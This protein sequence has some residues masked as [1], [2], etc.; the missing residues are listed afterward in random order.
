MGRETETAQ[1]FFRQGCRRMHE[2]RLIRMAR[3]NDGETVGWTEHGGQRDR[4]TIR[5]GKGNM[6]KMAGSDEQ[7]TPAVLR[8]TVELGID[9]VLSI[10]VTLCLKGL[11][12]AGEIAALLGLQSRHVLQDDET[13]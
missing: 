2:V 3:R 6:R 11:Q 13:W 7:I 4:G 9:D 1:I 12:K 8:N 10:V 5:L